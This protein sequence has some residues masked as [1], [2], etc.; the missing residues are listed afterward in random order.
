M[1]DAHGF[2]IS[3]VDYAGPP[4]LKGG[5]KASISLFTWALHRAIHIELVSQALRR[6]ITRYDRPKTIYSDTGTNF[7]G[8]DH[9]LTSI[10]RDN[11]QKY[12]TIQRME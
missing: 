3:G 8:T 1:R 6:F 10:K 4:H 5:E 9:L 2:Q 12:A 7:V 11:V